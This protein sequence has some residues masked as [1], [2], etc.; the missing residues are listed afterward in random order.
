M[1]ILGWI[2]LGLVVGVIAN[3][4]DPRPSK[5]GILGAIVL[6]IVG[7]LVGGFLGSALLGVTVTGFNF[8]SVLIAVIGALL[9]LL[10]GRAFNR[11][12]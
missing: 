11:S 3:A 9:V 12:V 6:G 7:A 2:L 4:L 8:G 1:N 5:G 10:V